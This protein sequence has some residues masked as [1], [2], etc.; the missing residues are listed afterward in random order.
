MQLSES[1][2]SLISVVDE[3][4][5]VG[6]WP[7]VLG[8][9]DDALDNNHARHSPIVR[10]TLHTPSG[11]LEPSDRQKILDKFGPE[12]FARQFADEVIIDPKEMHPGAGISLEATADTLTIRQPHLTCP[13]G[14]IHN[15]ADGY[16]L[17]P[18]LLDRQ[19]TII[20]STRT[21]V[22]RQQSVDPTSSPR[23]GRIEVTVQHH[24]ELIHSPLSFLAGTTFAETL[25][26]KPTT[27]PKDNQQEPRNW[28]VYQ[29]QG[30]L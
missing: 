4:N 22:T 9:F 29:R 16:H 8:A 15:V 18:D 10:T 14:R 27:P 2:P 20:D 30:F 19:E 12:G 7:D 21:R 28:G 1:S 23:M 6:T 5:G 17:Y 26:P 3:T 13:D 11:A 25:D 24:V